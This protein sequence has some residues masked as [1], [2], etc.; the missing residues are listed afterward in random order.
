MKYDVAIVGAGPAGLHAAKHAAAGGLRV[1][2]IEKR[3]D[4][5]KITRY[6]SEHIILD[7]NYNGDTIVVEPGAPMQGPHRIVPRNNNNRIRS[8]KFGWELTYEGVL[9][10]C[11]DKFYYSADLSH[12]AHFAWPDRRP[13][14]WKYDKGALQQQLL[15]EVVRLGVDYVTETTC[16]EARDSKTDAGVLLKCVSKGRRFTLQA[17]KLI[18]ADG[19]SAQVAQSL[20]IN[21]DR[22]FF[23]AAGVVAIYLS[24]VK[25]YNPNEWV[26]FWG[27]CYGSHYAPLIGTGPVED[28]EWADLIVIGTPQQKALDLYEY[29]TTKSPVAWM[30]EDARV[31]QKHSCMTKAFAPLKKPYDGNCLIIGDAAAFVEVQAQGA[32]SCGYWAA[33]AVTRELQGLPGF[34]EYTR[35]WLETFEFNDDG[36]MQVT[37]GYALIPYYTDEQVVYLFSLLDGITLNGSWSQYASPRM[38][39]AEIHKH[40]GRIQSERPDIW[41]K[42]QKQQSRMLGD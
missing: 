10:P 40:D 34:E 20:G 37:T 15:D 8:A 31:E 5:S 24:G 11:L 32:L 16:Y 39:W 36:M 38:M 22:M 27:Q 35:T 21:S 2:L 30:F 41:E 9:C 3:R 17:K 19:A 29:F 18:A 28:H 23:A 1:A 12:N 4:I 7:E 6:C 13:I 33:G 42:I 14:A 25:N 26:G